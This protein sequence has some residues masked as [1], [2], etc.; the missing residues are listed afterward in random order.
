MI[1]YKIYVIMQDNS[2]SIFS[3]RKLH[4]VTIDISF[5]YFAQKR[6]VSRFLAAEFLGFSHVR[7]YLYVY[8]HIHEYLV[9]LKL[10]SLTL[11]THYA[12]RDKLFWK[13]SEIPAA[14]T[15][16]S[17][18]IQSFPR[19]CSCSCMYISI[20]ASWGQLNLSIYLYTHITITCTSFWLLDWTLRT[21]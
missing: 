9:E 17:S 3:L 7:M 15:L 12:S 4:L 10:L 16:F 1:I 18:L 20:K 13:V 2:A 14:Y 11:S 19:S 21:I 8:L 6:S 5:S